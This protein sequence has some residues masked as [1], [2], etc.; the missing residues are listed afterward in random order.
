[1]VWVSGA[2]TVDMVT[3]L[4]STREE[5]RMTSAWS[6]NVFLDSVV[7]MVN[8]VLSNEGDEA[9]S[10]IYIS[11]TRV[12]A[13]T[14]KRQD[15]QPHEHHEQHLCHLHNICDLLREEPS[16]YKQLVQ[17]AK[18]ICLGCGRAAASEENLCAPRPLYE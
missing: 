4:S 10:I 14:M 3:S 9:T 6:T 8:M 17:Q 7:E 11:T 2:R 12:E 1:M 15:V 5:F 16:A 18:Y 13:P